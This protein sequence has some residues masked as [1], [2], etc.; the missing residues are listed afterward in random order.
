MS[1]RAR[2]AIVVSGITD[3]EADDAAERLLAVHG[4]GR[5]TLK[6]IAAWLAQSGSKLGGFGRARTGPSTIPTMATE[7][8]ASSMDVGVDQFLDLAWRAGLGTKKR[9]DLGTWSEWHLAWVRR[10]A[11]EV[12]RKERL[13]ESWATFPIQRHQEHEPTSAISC[14]LSAAI[15]LGTVKDDGIA[16]ALDVLVSSKAATSTMRRTPKLVEKG[17]RSLADLVGLHVYRPNPPRLEDFRFD[18]KHSDNVWMVLLR[19]RFVDPAGRAEPYE[20]NS[21]VLLLD[22]ISS[23]VV[24]ADPHPWHEPISLM[25]IAAFLG[26]WTTARPGNRGWAGCL[27]RW[28]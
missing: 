8:A 19:Q 15:Y 27:S 18:E 28:D 24:I 26:A 20:A 7:A 16:S 23:G 6:E 1:L 13:F 2:D 17:I 4:C 9:P 25:P 21:F 14:L 12:A 5:K 11:R 3:F 10:I 22:L